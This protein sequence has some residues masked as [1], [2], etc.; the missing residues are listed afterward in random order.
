M[1]A[2]QEVKYTLILR[3]FNTQQLAAEPVFKAC[4][5]VHTRQLWFYVQ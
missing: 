4:F 5:G 3:V 1:L 2:Y